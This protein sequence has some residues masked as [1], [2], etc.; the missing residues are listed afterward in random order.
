MM[1]IA[2]GAWSVASPID[3]AG[4][5]STAG[6]AAP[7]VESSSYVLP[8]KVSRVTDGDSIQVI[9]SSGP[10]K[11]R[12]A[13]IDA[14]ERGQ[15][16]GREAT[17]ALA[18]RLQ[19]RQ[20]GLEVVEQRDGFDRMVAIVWLGDENINEWLVR[21]GYAWAF[22]GLYLHD[23]RLCALE[24]T[25]RDAHLGL[26]GRAE[27]NYAP[28]EWRHVRPGQYDRLKDFERE[29]VAECAAT[30]TAGSRDG[31]GVQ[32]GVRGQTA[33]PGVSGALTVGAVHS[34][35]SLTSPASR[36]TIKG[37]VSRSGRIYHLPDSA[38]YARTL[39]DESRG[40]RWFCSEDEARAAGWR[41]PRE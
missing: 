17:A 31:A 13:S 33:A 4:T 10:I 6:P 37:N 21:Q 3:A 24:R 41:A 40:E 29:T 34:A 19:G 7:Q 8:G 9:L 26:W 28:W 30:A 14:P 2:P 5:A 32:P 27:R 23:P 36:C 18:A 16:G 35:T 22:R 39:I 25:A 1:V 15:P 11:V 38:G 12:L 20:V